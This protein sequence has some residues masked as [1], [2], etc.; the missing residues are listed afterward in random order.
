V[1][2]RLQL[3]QQHQQHQ[4]WLLAGSLVSAFAVNSSAEA[5]WTGFLC[6]VTVCHSPTCHKSNFVPLAACTLQH[7]N[8]G[9]I[10]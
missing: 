9:A 6:S 3:H 1:A 4:Q 5:F 7:T 8:V 2:Q 10:K